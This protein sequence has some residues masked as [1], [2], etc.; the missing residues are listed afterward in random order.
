MQNRLI[1]FSG[2]SLT[3]STST[4][5]AH[6]RPSPTPSRR[7]RPRPAMR[8]KLRTRHEHEYRHP[9]PFSPFLLQIRPPLVLPPPPP[10]P[11]RSPKL[12]V[13]FLP[14]R[15]IHHQPPAA[16]A[17]DSDLVFSWLVDEEEGE[18]GGVDVAGVVLDV[19]G[20][21]VQD[22]RG[23]ARQRRQDHHALQAPPRGGRHR[24][25]HHRQQRRGGR[26]QEHP[27]RG[28]TSPP[29]PPLFAFFS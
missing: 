8:G 24:R 7:L 16:A 28:L 10:S 11:I 14:R 20:E 27:I 13:H 1:S 4:A 5:Q 12:A 26:L 23:G 2:G 29:S 3:M 19:P 22:R 17:R 18:D 6:G 21:G 9:I 15:S 25:T